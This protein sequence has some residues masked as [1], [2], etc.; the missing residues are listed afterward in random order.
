MRVTTRSSVLRT[1]A[2]VT[3][4]QLLPPPAAWS[5]GKPILPLPQALQQEAVVPVTVGAG[6]ESVEIPMSL[7]GGAYCVLYSL[8]GQRFRA[9]VD[10]GSPFL[11]VD[12]TCAAC[13]S[14][15]A[16]AARSDACESSLWGCY[17]GVGRPSGL[18]DTVEEFGGEDVGTQW[19]EGDVVLGS[20]D[21]RSGPNLAARDV[22]FGV[23]R[24]YV[25]KGGGGAVFLGLA[26][27]RQPRIR[28]TL[29]E[30]TGV[31]SLRFAFLRKQMTLARVPLIPPA[32]DAIR[33]LDLRRR[34][35]PVEVYGCT[36]QRLVVNGNALELDRPCI[37]VIDTGTTGLSVSESL[38]CNAQL[39][40]GLGPVRDCRIELET[41]AGRTCALE[42]SVRR[43]QRPSSDVP[44][45]AVPADAPEI[46]A[47]PFVVSSV[48]VPWF[49]PDFGKGDGS[50]LEEREEMEA[51]MDTGLDPYAACERRARRS[52]RR[53]PSRG[54]PFPGQKPHVL[55]VGLAFLWRREVTID[56][57]ARRL[58]IT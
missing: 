5:V 38:F 54:A 16:R 52:D 3:V 18:A 23:V 28:P 1:L 33:L 34:G 15:S 6:A 35:A 51:R 26:K 31:V 20:W 17:R 22:V 37:A 29:L 53:P 24:S 4:T 19:R 57:D 41:E 58:Q 40:L 7:C 2:A 47:F 13:E 14:A 48:R 43:K 42:A 55:F 49:E 30:Q 12:G 44:Q 45:V 10:T 56:V 27:R 39:G 25:G 32:A 21:A 50:R 36:V 9:V 46:D 11:L 8:D